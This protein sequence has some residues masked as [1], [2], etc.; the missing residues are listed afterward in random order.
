MDLF[1]QFN[2][3]PTNLQCVSNDC[4][5]ALPWLL[6]AHINVE[7]SFLWRVVPWPTHHASFELIKSSLGEG[8][9]AIPVYLSK[10]CMLYFLHYV[11]YFVH[12]TL[13]FYCRFLYIL[14]LKQFECVAR[15]AYLNVEISYTFKLSYSMRMRL[16]EGWN[17]Y[18]RKL[19]LVNN[20]KNFFLKARSSSRS[21]IRVNLNSV[22]PISL[23]LYKTMQ[24]SWRK[25]YK[26][27]IQ[28][29]NYW[30]NTFCGLSVPSTIL[31]THLRG[32]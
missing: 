2:N 1:T 24:K 9:A 21:N 20:F 6:E 30:I 5:T 11:Y 28:G 26:C 12:I 4:S 19:N 22:N 14:N 31:L 8:C 17:S 7:F 18:L 29:S 23:C 13:I 32:L 10:F 15:V 25:I 3:F 16:K 27:C